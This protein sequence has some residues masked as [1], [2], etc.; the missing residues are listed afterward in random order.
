MKLYDELVSN[1][2]KKRD[3]IIKSDEFAE[4]VSDFKTVVDK[5]YPYEVSMSKGKYKFTTQQWSLVVE[6][7]ERE[8]IILEDDI[9]SVKFYTCRL[10][11]KK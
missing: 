11:D 6:I 8:G 2:D 10:K 3:E 7:F 5:K 4:F 1:L 9:G